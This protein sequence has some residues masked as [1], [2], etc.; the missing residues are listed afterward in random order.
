MAIDHS[1]RP[2]GS[3]PPIFET[4]SLVP[5]FCLLRI[6]TKTTI[7]P[8]IF[9]EE[10]GPLISP[11]NPDDYD[12]N[13]KYFGCCEI[14]IFPTSRKTSIRITSI[15]KRNFMRKGFLLDLFKRKTSCDLTK[16]I[17]LNLKDS[18]TRPTNRKSW[19]KQMALVVDDKELRRT[20]FFLLGGQNDFNQCTQEGPIASSLCFPVDTNWGQQR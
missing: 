17:M 2:T 15:L 8:D 3:H 4:T 10:L 18:P 14:F 5:G 9:E 19:T 11:A 16:Q 20:G 7:K 13:S 1:R 12:G 6:F